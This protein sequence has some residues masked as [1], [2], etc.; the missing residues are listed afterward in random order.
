M[1]DAKEALENVS[2]S[3]LPPAPLPP[4]F[5]VG[6]EGE[7]PCQLLPTYTLLVGGQTSP[8]SAPGLDTS[9]VRPENEAL[10]GEGDIQVIIFINMILDLKV[11]VVKF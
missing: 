4:A 10:V 6:E 2:K 8:E 9:V 1:E 7:L 11:M 5:R 3:Y